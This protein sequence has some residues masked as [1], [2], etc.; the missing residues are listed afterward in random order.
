MVYSHITKDP[1]ICG[2]RACIDGTRVRVLDLVALEYGGQ[3]PAQIQ[4]A[5]PNLSL[6]QVYAGLSYAHE[7]P[8]EIEAQLDEDRRLAE[9]IDRDRAALR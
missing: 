2:G 9:R 8:Q 3:S 7:Y 5:Y 6:A 4:G 1:E